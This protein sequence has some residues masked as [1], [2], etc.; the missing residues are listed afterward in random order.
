MKLL[1]AMTALSAAAGFIGGIVVMS[2]IENREIQQAMDDASKIQTQR[3]VITERAKTL[4]TDAE[5]LGAVVLERERDILRLRDKLNIT[6]AR[7]QTVMARPIPEDLAPRLDELQ[8]RIL[9]LVETTNDQKRLIQAQ[10]GAISGLQAQLLATSEA[11]DAWKRSA[12]EGGREALQLR[13]ALAAQ[14]GI[15]KNAVWKGRIQGLA[16]GL[17]AGYIGGR[18]K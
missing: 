12:E 8:S 6:Q 14:Q 3:Q 11:R 7:L 2:W 9:V 15:A 10:D 18:L 13:A 17:G 4:D 1:L 5:R 16:V